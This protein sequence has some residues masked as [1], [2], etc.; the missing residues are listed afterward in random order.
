MSDKAIIIKDRAGTLVRLEP[1]SAGSDHFLLSVGL[2]DTTKA[3]GTIR[4]GMAT[5][6]VVG[7]ETLL[8]LYN[9]IEYVVCKVRPLTVSV[10]G[11]TKTVARGAYDKVDLPPDFWN[12]IA[13]PGAPDA[14]HNQ[15]AGE[16]QP[17]HTVQDPDL[18]V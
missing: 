5:S 16:A 10:L 13:N 9:H 15:A 8:Q 11:G 2:Q 17:D 1:F 18:Q 7:E 14:D 6:V 3:N 4:G 12:T